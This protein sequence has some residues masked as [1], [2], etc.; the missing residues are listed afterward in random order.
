LRVASVETGFFGVLIFW[1]I[2]KTV[3]NSIPLLYRGKIYKSRGKCQKV[4]HFAIL[5]Y[6]CIGISRKF[7]KF[8]VQTLDDPLGLGYSVYMTAVGHIDNRENG[9]GVTNSRMAPK[10]AKG[11]FYGKEKGTRNQNRGTGR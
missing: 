5:L 4:G 3:I 9:N 6:R 2:S 1:L 7:L 10:R 11:D 8:F